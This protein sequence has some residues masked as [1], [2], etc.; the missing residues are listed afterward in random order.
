MLPNIS[1]DITGADCFFASACPHLQRLRL[2]LDRPLTNLI[3]NMSRLGHIQPYYGT[4]TEDG[5]VEKKENTELLDA[6]NYLQITT[7][8]MIHHTSTQPFAICTTIRGMKLQHHQPDS[9]PTLS[10]STTVLPMPPLP[11]LLLLFRLFT[12]FVIE[13]LSLQTPQHSVGDCERQCHTH[14][15]VGL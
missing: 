14:Q 2:L 15:H 4:N 6:R 8:R 3:G 5:Q 9:V 13:V 7:R 12:V 1:S 11:L 10:S